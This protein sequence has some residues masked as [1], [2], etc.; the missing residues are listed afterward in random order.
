MKHDE[1]HQGV[2]SRW[3]LPGSLAAHLLVIALLIFG[4]PLPPL[5]Q[6]EEQPIAVDLV[7]PESPEEQKAEPPARPEEPEKPEEE[8][9]E[10]PPAAAR[11]TARP[12]PQE[13]LKPVFRFGEKDG[14][15]RKSLDGDGAEEG[16]ESAEATSEEGR[17]EAAKPPALEAAASPDQAAPSEDPE[18]AA[19]KATDAPAKQEARKPGE[20]K[21]LFSQSATGDAI[22][23]TAIGEVP[24]GVRAGRLC[25]T[26]LREQLRNTMPPYYPDLLPSFKLGEGTVIDARRA[27]MRVSGEWYDLSY[28]CE[29]DTDA[30]KVVAF[31]FRVGN[32]LPPS[33]WARRGLPIR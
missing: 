14:G 5:K 21:R 29:V 22:A 6:Q 7:P 10:K 18:A 12:A 25:V 31:S 15:P 32:L 8:K 4:V 1:Q 20:A 9:A 23:T 13:V 30:T 11:E 3:A 19:P 16:S 28:R 2:A 24:R 27:A 26:E 33:E 17:Q